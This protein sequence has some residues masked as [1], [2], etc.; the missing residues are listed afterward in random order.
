MRIRFRLGSQTRR[1][2]KRARDGDYRVT[3]GALVVDD[4]RSD[5]GC[6]RVHAGIARG[7]SGLA[8]QVGGD[9]AADEMLARSRARDCRLDAAGGDIVGCGGG[10][11]GGYG[12]V[13]EFSLDLTGKVNA[14]PIRFGFGRG[15]SYQGQRRGGRNTSNQ[16]FSSRSEERALPLRVEAEW[17][18]DD[19]MR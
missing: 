16:H 10:I 6:C 18:G 11:D 5:A 8:T 19:E 7:A 14:R 1:L 12:R 9:D 4:G 3:A 17:N 13:V 15:D 2:A